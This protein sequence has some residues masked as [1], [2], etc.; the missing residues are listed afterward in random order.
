HTPDK[1]VAAWVDEQRGDARIAK[2][3]QALEGLGLTVQQ[4]D[5][6]RLDK[7]AGGVNH[8]AWCCGC[9]CRPNRARTS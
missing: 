7:M 5:R 8:Q 3:R 6:R 2:I 9:G 1:V 4:S